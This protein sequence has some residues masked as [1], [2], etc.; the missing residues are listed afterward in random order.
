MLTFMRSTGLLFFAAALAVAGGC[1]GG[2]G[3]GGMDAGPRGDDAGPPVGGGDA[4]V[5]FA[6]V[7]RTPDPSCT[8]TWVVGMQGRVVDESGR[9]V[10]GAFPQICIRIAVTDRLLC[11]RPYPA[12]PDGSYSILIPETERCMDRAAMRSLLP[13]ADF[14]PTYC[15]LA[16]TPSDGIVDIPDVTL[17]ATSAPTDLPPPGDLEA[18][19][20]VT[21]EDGLEIDVRPRGMMGGE[22]AYSSLAAR[23]LSPSEAGCITRDIPSGAVAVYAISPEAGVTGGAFPVRIPNSSGL[24]AGSAVEIYVLGG[25]STVLP[26]GAPLAEAEWGLVGTGTVSTDGATVESDPGAGLSYLSWMTF[27]PA[28]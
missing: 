14:A 19:R 12:A 9:G 4:G 27:R 10:A 17:Y 13:D 18:P 23:R 2:G 25:L 26:D 8:G 5:D 6:T 21:F 1:G 24:P 20:T 11:L 15:D 3:G 16:L 22:P 28:P 7:D